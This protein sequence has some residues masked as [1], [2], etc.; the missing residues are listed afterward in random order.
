MLTKYYT[1]DGAVIFFDYEDRLDDIPP[2]MSWCPAPGSEGVVIVDADTGKAL[3]NQVFPSRNVAKRLIRVWTK[4]KSRHRSTHAPVCSWT[5]AE[6]L[7]RVR[8]QPAAQYALLHH[9]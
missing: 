1:S 7:R 6:I 2:N 3:V 9:T 4:S 5:K 8:M